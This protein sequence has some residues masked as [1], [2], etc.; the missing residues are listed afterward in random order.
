MNT[1]LELTLKG[2]LVLPG[3]IVENGIVGVAGGK[4]QGIYPA[5]GAPGAAER[6]D[7]TGCLI[8]PGLV[9]PHVHSLSNPGEGVAAATAAA[10][11]GGVATVIEMPYDKAGAINTPERFTAK[12]AMVEKESHVDIALLATL[13]KK[14]TKEEVE[15]LAKLGPCGV[16]LSVFETDPERFPR[17]DD[18]VLWELL[19]ELSRFGIV[20]SF[21]AENDVIIEHLIARAK[22]AGNTG[23]R[24]HCLTRPPVTESLAVGKLLELAYWIGF[25]LH[26]H[27]VSHPHCFEMARWYRSKGIKNLSMETCPHYLALCED[28]METIGAMGKI[29]PPLR[30][31]A[32]VEALWEF[33]KSGEVDIVASDHAPW[34]LAQKNNGST[35]N[36]FSSASGA[37]GLESLF[38]IMYTEGFARR[39]L[40]LTRLAALLAENPARRFGL[41]DRKGRIEAGLD[42]DF[43]VV[44]PGIEWIYDASGSRSSAKWSPYAGRKLKGKIIRTIQRGRA[45]FADGELLAKPGDGRFLPVPHAAG[46]AQ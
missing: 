43:A 10:A 26:I 17:I 4:I 32:A 21:H 28:D 36:I 44:D 2:N 37:P 9:D 12:R 18:D 14:A 13:A 7:F 30:D 1:S 40:P 3:Q 6:L 24:H 20:T 15:P 16:K 31:K 35:E 46:R 33:V 42:A 5:D 45:I 39:G 25:P 22:A 34:S 41:G 27:H 11:A 23:A 38:A 29:N 8:F 19:P